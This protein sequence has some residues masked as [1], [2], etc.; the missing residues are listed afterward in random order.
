MSSKIERIRGGRTFLSRLGHAST[1]LLLGAGCTGQTTKH[2]ESVREV[3]AALVAEGA[4]RVSVVLNGPA[5][6]D[7]VADTLTTPNSKVV[8]RFRSGLSVMIGS[9]SDVDALAEHPDVERFGVTPIAEAALNDSRGL[10]G[11]DE[12]FAAGF[13]GAGRRMAILDTG[14]ATTHDDLQADIVDEACFCAGCCPDGSSQQLGPGAAE[15]EQG[16]G[17]HVA[18]IM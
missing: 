15:D 1:L 10:V 9:E 18:G 17:T 14:I 6:R 8:H 4:T 2:E 5:A 13:N 12:A 16:H 3:R 7:D 11:A